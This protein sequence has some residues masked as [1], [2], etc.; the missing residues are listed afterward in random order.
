MPCFQQNAWLLVI[1][2][3][4]IKQSNSINLYVSCF[5]V[6]AYRISKYSINMVANPALKH[7]FDFD[8]LYQFT[9]D[10]STPRD[11]ITRPYYNQSILALTFKGCVDAVGKSITYYSRQ[12]VY[13]RVILWRVPLLALWLTATLPPFGIHTQTFTLL[14]LVGDPIDSIWSLL[15]RLDLA[16]RTVRWV[17][18]K[19]VVGENGFSFCFLP[20]SAV[21]RASEANE[22]NRTCGASAETNAVTSGS[23]LISDMWDEEDPE[24]QRYCYG[25][26]A[27]I[28]TAYDDWGKGREASEAMYYFL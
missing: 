23:R 24:L 27:L 3:P 19:D 26:P 17:Q 21:T 20:K 7:G 22:G 8:Y 5:K 9:H 11:Y 18:E 10:P 12:G 16:K 14:H 15:Y 13:D 28:V 25:V 4:G 6:T 2:H 1:S